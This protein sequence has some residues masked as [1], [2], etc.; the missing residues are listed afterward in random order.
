MRRSPC[1]PR[2]LVGRNSTRGLPRIRVAGLALARLALVCYLMPVILLV[3]AI[4]GLAIGLGRLQQL[5][6][7]LGDSLPGRTPTMRRLV[8]IPIVTRK[9]S[10][11]RRPGSLHDPRGIR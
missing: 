10:F 7:S 5:F 4:G 3:F 1:Q 11:T 2:S 8:T 6:H 9:A